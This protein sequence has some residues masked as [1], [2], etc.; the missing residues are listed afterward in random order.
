MH[1]NVAIVGPFQWLDHLGTSNIVEIN[2]GVTVAGVPKATYK[3]G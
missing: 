1:C 3:F 2:G